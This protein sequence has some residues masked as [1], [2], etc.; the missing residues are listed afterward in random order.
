MKKKHW[1]QEITC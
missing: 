1:L